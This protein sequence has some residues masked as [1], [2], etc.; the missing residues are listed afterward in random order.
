MTSTPDTPLDNTGSPPSRE[1]PWSDRAA[2]LVVFA[3]GIV[4]LVG[5]QDISDE[6]T[7][8]V[9]P[10]AFPLIIAVLTTAVGVVLIG[11]EAIRTRAE[12]RTRLQEPSTTSNAGE[13][14]WIKPHWPAVAGIIASLIAYTLV[15]ETIGYWQT[16][17]VFFV[18]VCR[19]LG[20]RRL[21]RDCLIAIVLALVI[22]YTFDQL[23]GVTL[24]P[25]FIR[26]AI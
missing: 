17:A 10:R 25:G 26:L 19:I 11:Q 6:A 9:G 5:A 14:S 4:L 21:W 24:P 13:S 22:F 23:L 3:L 8:S 18:A 12:R 1:A 20:S 7:R 16:T 15:M 2:A